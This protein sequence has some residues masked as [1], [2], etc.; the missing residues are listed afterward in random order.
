MTGY[1]DRPLAGK[2]GITAGSEVILVDAPAG[3]A[4]SRW[5]QRARGTRGAVTRI[6]NG[7]VHSIG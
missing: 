2:L 1:S 4:G 3:R 5:P 7:G 6:R